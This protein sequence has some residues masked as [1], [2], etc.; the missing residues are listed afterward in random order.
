[1]ACICP[2]CL[3]EMTYRA[4]SLFCSICDY[5]LDLIHESEQRIC[6]CLCPQIRSITNRDVCTSCGGKIIRQVAKKPT[7]KQIALYLEF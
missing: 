6:S 1:M 2:Y 3:R 5:E 4:G 7:K